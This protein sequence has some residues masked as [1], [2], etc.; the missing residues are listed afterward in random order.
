MWRGDQLLVDTEIGAPS[1]GQMVT[2]GR[3][4]DHSSSHA[5]SGL[6]H[7]VRWITLQSGH[8]FGYFYGFGPHGDVPRTK[9]GAATQ[10]G[11]VFSGLCFHDSCG[12]LRAVTLQ[13]DR[14]AACIGA[15]RYF[16]Y[17][18]NPVYPGQPPRQTWNSKRGFFVEEKID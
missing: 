17:G 12:Q 16:V 2:R 3:W 13:A 18:M 7:A 8:R 6:E 10:G 9:L 15:D 14:L 1:F 4:A 5:D 11:R